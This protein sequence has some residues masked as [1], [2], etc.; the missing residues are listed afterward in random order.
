MKK[1]NSDKDQTSPAIMRKGMRFYKWM[2]TLLISNIL[3]HELNCTFTE[4]H[5]ITKKKYE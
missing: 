4:N 5:A 2:V 1:R 3:V